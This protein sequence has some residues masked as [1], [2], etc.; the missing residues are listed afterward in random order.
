VCARGDGIRRSKDLRAEIGKFPNSTNERKQM[1]T[2]TIKQRVALVALSALGAGLLSVV[3]VSSASADANSAPNAATPTFAEDVLNIGT[4]ANALG[5]AVATVDAALSS[6]GLVATSDIAGGRVAGTTQTAIL[7]STGTLAVGTDTS[8]GDYAVITVEGGTIT[9]GVGGDAVNSGSTAVV[10]TGG[11]KF[12]A[13]I[14]PNSGVTSMIVR[15]YSASASAYSS[16]ASVALAAPSTGTLFGQITVTIA[17]TSA[18]G[19]MSPAE[20]KLYFAPTTSSTSLTTDSL[21][22]TGSQSNGGLGCVNIQLND[23]YGQDITSPFGLLTVTATN[24]AVVKLDASTCSAGTTPGSTFLA[25]ASPA[26]VVVSVVQPVGGVAL[27]TTLTVS[28]NGAVVG[29]KAFTFRGKVAKVTVSSPKIG[30][31][32]GTSDDLA[33]VKF[34]D[35]AGNVIYPTSSS[36]AY[37]LNSSTLAITASTATSV[38]SSAG[39]AAT[40]VPNSSTGETGKISWSCGSVAGSSKISLNWVNTD[41]TVVTS[42]LFDAACAGPVYSYTASFDKASYAP[43]EV[44]TLSVAFKDIKGNATNDYNAFVTG[45]A[46]AGDI[47]ATISTGGA[48][49]AVTSPLAADRTTNGVKKYTYTV[50]ST[51]G[52]FNAIVKFAADDAVTVPYSVKAS[53]TNV[54]NED[55]LKS[56]VS[57]IASINKQIQALQKLI[58]KRR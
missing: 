4:T 39:I 17:A 56:I 44:A 45:T 54:T 41:G 51:T 31:L 32:D 26:N 43:G 14:K 12:S 29:T 24:N 16:S 2:K 18:S 23:A 50:G 9:G 8:S 27:S 36:T 48:L 33:K 46:A 3:P 47:D 20:S 21:T 58:L 40:T 13:L 52:S 7:L 25:S 38:T 49:T 42:N 19:V 57:L 35:A 5:A 15:A 53:G 28:Y 6:V 34:E 30:A 10:E 1:S 11:D 37:P 22:N 55:V